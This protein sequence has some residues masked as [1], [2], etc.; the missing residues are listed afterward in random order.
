[1]SLPG[2]APAAAWPITAL[3]EV[4]G[5]VPVEEKLVS[6]RTELESLCCLFCY[7]PVKPSE[8]QVTFQLKEKPWDSGCASQSAWFPCVMHIRLGTE[9]VSKNLKGIIPFFWN[10]HQCMVTMGKI[11]DPDQMA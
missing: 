10:R 3:A 4:R 11:P 5:S 9:L 6:P 8:C 2:S 1:M 7:L